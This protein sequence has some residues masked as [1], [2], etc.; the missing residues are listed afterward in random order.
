MLSEQFAILILQRLF[1]CLETVSTVAL[2]LDI[3]APATTSPS[4]IFRL[5]DER[6]MPVAVP[7]SLKRLPS[8]VIGSAW[9]S[10]DQSV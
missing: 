6:V 1:F 4:V 10:S 7:S 8:L 3:V 9:G 5:R 2:T